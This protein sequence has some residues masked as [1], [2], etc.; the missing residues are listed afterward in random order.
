MREQGKICMYIDGHASKRIIATESRN[1][2][3]SAE[4]ILPNFKSMP[5]VCVKGR[6][7]IGKVSERVSYKDAPASILEIFT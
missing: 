1:V 3:E 4:N 7:V 6:T 2:I 5:Q